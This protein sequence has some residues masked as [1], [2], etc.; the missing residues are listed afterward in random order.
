MPKL[1]I[2]ENEMDVESKSTNNEVKVENVKKEENIPSCYIEIKLPSCGRIEDYPKVLHFRDYTSSD[3]VDLNIKDDGDIKTLSKVLSR[4]NYENY[5]VSNLT[6]EDL[7]YITYV[8]H[9]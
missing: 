7:L 4:M 1:I 2:E 8:L 6:P 5:D 3:V 9:M